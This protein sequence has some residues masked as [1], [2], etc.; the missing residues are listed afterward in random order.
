MVTTMD[1][2]TVDFD[3]FI[4]AGIDSFTKFEAVGWGP[5]FTPNEPVYPEMV[6]EFYA[7]LSF[8]DELQGVSMIKGRKV[9]LTPEYLTEVIGC[10]NKG[11][12]RYFSHKEVPFE[13]YIR[14]R[15]VKELMGGK[16]GLIDVS[17]MDVSIRVPSQPSPKRLCP[18]L[19]SL[20]YPRLLKPSIAGL[21][22]IEFP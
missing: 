13:G 12:Q 14:D 20:T 6:K 8:E 19:V 5:F 22:F 1:A 18:K 4:N 17:K 3:F 21:S 10:P 7:N 16:A 15:A 2:R 11:V 9:V